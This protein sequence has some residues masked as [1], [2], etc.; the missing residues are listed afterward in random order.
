MLPISLSPAPKVKKIIILV[1]GYWLLGFTPPIANAFSLWDIFPPLKMSNKPEYGNPPAVN[2]DEI[3][4]QGVSNSTFINQSQDSTTCHSYVTV[5]NEWEARTEDIRDENNKKIG[6]RIVYPYDANNLNEEY[7]AQKQSNTSGRDVKSVYLGRGDASADVETTDTNFRSL[8]TDGF[9]SLTKTL[10][11]DQK[12]CLQGQAIEEMIKGLNKEE[13]DY[14][15]IQLGWENGGQFIEMR[16]PKCSPDTCRPV[17]VG[18]VA[19]YY[20]N[21]SPSDYQKDP[22]I[23]DSCTTME[24]KPMPDLS[25]YSTKYKERFPYSIVPFADT[26]I[27]TTIL[28]KFLPIKALGTSDQTVVISNYTVKTPCTSGGDCSNF[29]VSDPVKTQ[30]H[31]TTPLAAAGNPKLT[32]QWSSAVN[33]ETN[34]S[35]LG[36]AGE[37]DTD[38]SATTIGFANKFACD[39]FQVN[40]PVGEDLPSPF[41]FI[42]EVIG[43]IRGGISDTPTWQFHFNNPLDFRVPQ[44]PIDAAFNATNDMANFLPNSDDE[45]KIVYDGL[46]KL[47]ASSK[48]MEESPYNVGYQEGETFKA[49]RCYLLPQEM[50]NGLC[51]PPVP[52]NTI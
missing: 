11:I 4:T 44:K 29:Q 45:D 17:T 26:T 2:V 7:S 36:G 9:N 24:P 41:S 40:G 33:L 43:E 51:P 27:Y 48:V 22:L 37:P 30:F 10:G 16:D 52:N 6:E 19:Y 47:P 14:A 12:L 50:Q 49:I 5:H 39:Q 23:Y 38:T 42:A 25:S 20:F 32:N 8:N 46:K 18:E 31:Y 34:S 21:L 3:G 15:D 1:I 35:N 28:R 13:T